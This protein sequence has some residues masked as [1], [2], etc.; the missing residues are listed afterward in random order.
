MTDR[1]GSKVEG[2]Q[3]LESMVVKQLLDASGAFKGSGASGSDL[4]MG[5]F[6]EALAD[7]V[8]KSGGFGLASMLEKQIGGD[9]AEAPVK[10]AWDDPNSDVALPDGYAAPEP[11]S[12]PLSPQK[13]APKPSQSVSSAFVSRALIKYRERADGGDGGKTE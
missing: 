2:Y 7:A 9:D 5:L 13:L 11:G 1:I 6:V 8:A 4:R 10:G 12:E 3:Q